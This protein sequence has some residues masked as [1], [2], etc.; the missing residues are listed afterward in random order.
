[1]KVRC[2]LLLPG[3]TL[4]ARL[5]ESPSMVS[6]TATRTVLEI[7]ADG[8]PVQLEPPTALGTEVV[9]ASPEEWARLRDAGFDLPR[10]S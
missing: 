6:R 8:A 10:A 4:P 5:V 2:N 9:E 1:M 7:D 3:R